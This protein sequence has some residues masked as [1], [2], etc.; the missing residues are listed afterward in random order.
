LKKQNKGGLL[1]KPG[2]HRKLVFVLMDGI[3]VKRPGIGSFRSFE[4]K[5]K[6]D[7]EHGKDA[8]TGK[9]VLLSADQF[10]ADLVSLLMKPL[11]D[12]ERDF[13]VTN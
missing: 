7:L 13:I 6:L 2:L 3:R 11:T 9:P 5:F 8:L 4:D 12:E 10:P 1:F